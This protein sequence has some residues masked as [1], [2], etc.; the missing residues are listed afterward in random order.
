MANDI[1]AQIE[2]EEAKYSDLTNANL[3][4]QHIGHSVGLFVVYVGFTW[5]QRSLFLFA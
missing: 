2:E 4:A 1:V 3:T 5:E